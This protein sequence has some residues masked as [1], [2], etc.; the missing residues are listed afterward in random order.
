MKEVKGS[1][2]HCAKNKEQGI[3]PPISKSKQ[4]M[5]PKL[6]VK[7]VKEVKGCRGHCAR[8]KE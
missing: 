5:P 1:G 8:N 2:I 3:S 4:I 7:K 6:L